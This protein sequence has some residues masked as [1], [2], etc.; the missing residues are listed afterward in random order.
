MNPWAAR[1]AA[2]AASGVSPPTVTTGELITSS[3]V[4]SPAAGWRRDGMRPAR[5]GF[6]LLGAVTSEHSDIAGGDR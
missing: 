5:H 4:M 1:S 2:A 6:L 3:A